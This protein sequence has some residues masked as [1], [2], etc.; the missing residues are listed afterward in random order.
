MRSERE[1]VD[2]FLTE[3]SKRAHPGKAEG[4][5]AYMKNKFAFFGISAP[6]RK[7]L[8]K[9]VVRKYKK[10]TV[11][12]MDFIAREFW[13]DEHREAQY[14]AMDLLER[15]AYFKQPNALALFEWL[16][17]SKSHWDTVDLLASTHVGG[18]FKYFPKDKERVVARWNASGSLWLIRTSIIFQLKYKTETN[19]AL[20]EK[21]I[22]PHLHDSEFFIQK[23]IGWAL[24]QLSKT[25][26]D[27][28]IRIAEKYPLSNLA[29][30]EGLKYV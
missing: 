29:K 18:Y 19:I 3:L 10:P 6:E 28:V 11:E 15:T 20:L 4:M 23:A 8:V 26:P 27:A 1:Y 22:V 13:V 9:D 17:L 30:R 24:R 12:Q 5:E 21:C 14:I 16:I 2:L 7:E 25:N